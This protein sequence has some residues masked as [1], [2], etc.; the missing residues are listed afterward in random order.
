MDKNNV[1]EINNLCK[2]YPS[3]CLDNVSFSVKKGK[4]VGFIGRNGAGKTTTIKS[5]LGFVHPDKGDVSFFGKNFKENE[6]EIKQNIGYVSGGFSYYS[7]KKIKQISKV[8]SSFYDNWDNDIYTKYMSKFKLD[9]EKT[10]AKLSEGMKVKYSIVLALSHK[11]Q[12]MILDEPTSGID[13]VSRDEILDIFLDL[14]EKGVTIFFSTHITSDLEKCADDIIYIQNGKIISNSSMTQL[15][16]NYKIVK[17]TKQQYEN[18]K[19]NCLIGAKKTKEG[20][21][22]IIKTENASKTTGTV[23]PA[24]L[25]TIM[26]HLEKEAE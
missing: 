19:N 7:N 15:V 12:L 2:N 1:I 18:E 22:A 20:Y 23:K 17:L 25:E 24:D 5:M 8:T 4:I 26:L 11:A 9:E 3:F 6:Q 16:D 13:P 14:Q 21:E 10:P